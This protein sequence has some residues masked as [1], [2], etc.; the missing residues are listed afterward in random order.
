MVVGVNAFSLFK[1]E[2]E[3]ANVALLPQKQHYQKGKIEQL[4]LS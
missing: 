4:D 3:K 2:K 1:K